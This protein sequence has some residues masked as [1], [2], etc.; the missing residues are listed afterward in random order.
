MATFQNCAANCKSDYSWIY[1]NS[2][3]SWHC[4]IHA[5]IKSRNCFLCSINYLVQML[6]SQSA[7][8]MEEGT[9]KFLTKTPEVTSE[10]LFIIN[11][12]SRSR[13]I[14]S[15]SRSTY[16]HFVLLFV[17]WN[18]HFYSKVPT[19]KSKVIEESWTLCTYLTTSDSKQLLHTEKF[20]NC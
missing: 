2:L 11:I 3:V 9:W 17:I 8:F 4:K 12:Y 20:W 6:S 1:L 16:I 5:S 18:W 19:K 10:G 13:Q 7:T 15:S 14:P